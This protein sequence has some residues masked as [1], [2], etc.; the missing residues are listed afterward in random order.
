M[1]TTTLVTGGT[2]T[3]GRLVV[4]RLRDAD[5]RVRVLTRHAHEP[6]DAI[7]YVLGDLSSGE[8]VAAAVA[9]VTTIVHC[10]GTSHGDED[11]AAHLVQAAQRA[12]VQHLVYISVVGAD[13]VPVVSGIDRAMFAYFASKRAAEQVIAASGIPWSTLRAAQ[14]YELC[15]MVSQQMSRLP[16][17][18]VPSG[19]RFQ[20]VDT[21][22]VADRLAELA[23]GTPAGLVPDIAGPR[24][25]GMDEMVRVYLRARHLRRA[26]VSFWLPGQAAGA[27]RA[28]ANLAPDRAVGQRTWEQFLAE[29]LN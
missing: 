2:G 3:L 22:E 7:D 18:P 11:K 17:I 15:L 25:Y 4:S 1:E 6:A 19:F 23:L 20:P 27:I 5:S 21:G 16:L 12:G 10:A 9:G 28:G 29:R 26:M 14:F 8:G 13:R 24:V